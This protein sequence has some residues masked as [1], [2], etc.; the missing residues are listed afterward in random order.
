M[1]AVQELN[2]HFMSKGATFRDHIILDHTWRHNQGQF[3]DFCERE[4]LS[5]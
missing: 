4:M 3:E 1:S 2:K 5:D